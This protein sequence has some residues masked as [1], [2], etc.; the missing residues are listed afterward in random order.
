MSASGGAAE[1]AGFMVS[2]S[3]TTVI[4]FSLTGSVIPA[5]EGLLTVLEV[6][7][8][9]PCM[10]DL[11]ISGAGGVPL[12]AAVDGCDTVVVVAPCDDADG[13]GIC[14]DVDDCVGEYDECGVCNG[15]GATYECWDGSVSYTH[16]TLPTKA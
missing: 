3:P 5:G 11:V 14:D 16:L 12:D 10:V 4:G 8:S 9:D 13:D 6:V 1:D 15:P 7:G 2:T